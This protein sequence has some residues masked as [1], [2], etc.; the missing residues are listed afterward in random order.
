MVTSKLNEFKMNKA[1]GIELVGTRMFIELS[2]EISDT[3]AELLNKSLTT[4]EITRDWGLANVTPRSITSL[5][6]RIYSF[7]AS[8]INTWNSLLN[9]ILDTESVNTFKTRLDKYWSQQPLLYD[10]K[11]EIAGRILSWVELVLTLYIKDNRIDLV[12]GMQRRATKLSTSMQ[13]LSYDD[14]QV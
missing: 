13:N 8:T 4:G 5:R 3:V 9:N 11:A 14:G 7:A 6:L 12:E 2:Q 1:S 10:F